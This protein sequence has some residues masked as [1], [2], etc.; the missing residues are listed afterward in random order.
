MQY[1]DPT[2]NL[3]IR[4]LLYLVS[5][6]FNVLFDFFRYILSISPSCVSNRWQLLNM[7]EFK[8][9]LTIAKAA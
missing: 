5:R 9:S 7:D 4:C 6:M 8:E 1:P 2:V 3:K